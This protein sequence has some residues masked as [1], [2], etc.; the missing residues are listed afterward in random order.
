MILFESV[1]SKS[2]RGMYGA[3]PTRAL[4]KSIVIC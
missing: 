3:S 4:R 2:W 1:D